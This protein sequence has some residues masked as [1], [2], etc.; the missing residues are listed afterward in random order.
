MSKFKYFKGETELH[1]VYEDNGRFFGYAEKSDLVWVKGEGWTGYQQ[2]DRKVKYKSN[3]SRHACDSRCMYATGK[4]MQ[5]ECAC[6]GKN[7]G[8]GAAIVCQAA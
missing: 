7:H 3:P 8:R 6:G 2:A 4:S 1:G 5:C